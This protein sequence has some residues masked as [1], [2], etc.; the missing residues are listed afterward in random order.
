MSMKSSLNK[1][2][3]LLSI[4]T[5]ACVY[6][7]KKGTLQ[8]LT[9]DRLNLF[10]INAI[11]LSMGDFWNLDKKLESKW[12]KSL[13]F[14]KFLGLPENTI[15]VL[16]PLDVTRIAVDGCNN[17]DFVKLLTSEGFRNYDID[18]VGSLLK[19]ITPDILVPLTEEPELKTSGHKSQNRCVKKT[20]TFL[21]RTIEYLNKIQNLERKPLIFASI[22]GGLNEM[23][24]VESTA[25]SVKRKI[26]GV[27]IHGLCAGEKY[28]ERQK[29]FD[30][31]NET[32]LSRGKCLFTLLK[33]KSIYM[34][35][36]SLLFTYKIPII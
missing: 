18:K 25:E 35:V 1:Q 9:L 22:Q 29:I 14:K 2:K 30:T 27:V 8:H 15:I 4:K 13:T 26:D 34:Y 11:L 36:L 23:L 21:D 3:S 19:I 20:I 28:E 31:I 17:I 33:K 7:S 10:N 24:R 12:P 5:P 6:Q 32:L 16:S